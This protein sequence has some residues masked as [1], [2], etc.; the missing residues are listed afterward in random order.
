VVTVREAAPEDLPFLLRVLAIAADWQAGVEARPVAE[1]LA[2]PDLAHYVPDLTGRDR[3]LVAQDERREDCGAAWWRFFDRGDSGY[4]FVE[5]DVP[6]VTVGV[7]AP[8]RGR[9]V[10][11]R[12]LRDLIALARDDRLPGLSLSVAPDNFARRLYAELAF[13]QVGTNGGSMTL[14]LSLRPPQAHISHE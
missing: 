1:V 11:R 7:L 9:R 4:G 6:E 5:A 8:S 2:A 3:G 10:G 14:L 13:V 12:L